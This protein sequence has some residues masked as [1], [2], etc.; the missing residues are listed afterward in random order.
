M[1]NM[2]SKLNRNLFFCI[3]L[4]RCYSSSAAQQKIIYGKLKASLNPSELKVTDISGGCGSMFAINIT[5]DCF[6]GLTIVKQHR[7]VNEVLKEDIKNWH[8]LQLHTKTK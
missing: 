1:T 3:D 5:S 4:V 7:I 8:G 6:K 2:L